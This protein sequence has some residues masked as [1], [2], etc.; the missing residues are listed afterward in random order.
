MQA[1]GERAPITEDW[2]K[3]V[4]FKWHEFERSGGK[5][6]LLWLGGAL[7]ESWT[8]TED[9]GLELAAGIRPSYWFC[10]FRSDTAHR[11]SRFVHVRHLKFQDEVITLI[12]AITGVPFKVENCMF[13]ALHSQK[14]ADYIRREEHDRLDRQ[15]LRERPRWRE[16]EKDDSRGQALPDHME[17]AEKA[18]SGKG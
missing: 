7:E 14:H 15:L 11:Y 17:A 4:G 16:I 13:G 6:W 1:N 8:G 12:E 10:W 3:S 9:I 5:H 18:R 2:L